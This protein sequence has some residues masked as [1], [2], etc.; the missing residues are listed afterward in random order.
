MRAELVEDGPRRRRGNRDDKPARLPLRTKPRDGPQV[1]AER[2]TLRQ[3][4][5]P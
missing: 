4:A 3:L 5:G 1:V 2:D